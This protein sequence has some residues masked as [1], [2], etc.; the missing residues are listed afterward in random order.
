MEFYAIKV[1]IYS[2]D[3]MGKTMLMA[4]ANHIL[5]YG[6]DHVSKYNGSIFMTISQISVKRGEFVNHLD[7]IQ[8]NIQ[9]VGEMEW[10]V[11][12]MII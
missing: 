9:V 4:D 2:C 7:I 10:N 3:S 6:D 11:I 12:W 5:Q 8:Q 1:L